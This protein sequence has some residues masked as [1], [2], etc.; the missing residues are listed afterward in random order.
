MHNCTAKS[1]DDAEFTNRTFYL[2]VSMLP[3]NLNMSML[4]QNQKCLKKTLNSYNWNDR[5]VPPTFEST[6]QTP[7]RR[8]K[9]SHHEV[10]R[11]KKAKRS[12]EPN[13][14]AVDDLT[15]AKQ[16]RRRR[17]KTLPIPHRQSNRVAK[18][19]LQ[20][21]LKDASTLVEIFSDLARTI[22]PELNQKSNRRNQ[23]NYCSASCL[24]VLESSAV[25][26]HPNS[27]ICPP[28]NRSRRPRN[29]HW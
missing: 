15:C 13:A 6:S 1:G 28:G 21:A 27:P 19:T 7:L 20:V 29:T 8:M 22:R 9:L 23:T 25:H 2:Y 3:Q 18:Y 5:R 10:R 16:F 14:K 24:G 17:R 26:R 11:T 4:P 12:K